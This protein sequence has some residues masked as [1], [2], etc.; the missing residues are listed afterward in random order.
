MTFSKMSLAST[1]GVVNDV[2]ILYHH[3]CL[4]TSV[5]GYPAEDISQSHFAYILLGGTLTRGQ[6]CGVFRSSSRTEQT[7]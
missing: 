1:Q 5:S 7:P 2:K 6:G 4:L 3:E